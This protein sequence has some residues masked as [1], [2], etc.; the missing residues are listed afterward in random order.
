MS[1][2]ASRILRVPVNVVQEQTNPCLTIDDTTRCNQLAKM[3]QIMHTVY[4]TLL[5]ITKQ[6]AKAKFKELPPHWDIFQFWWTKLKNVHFCVCAFAVNKEEKVDE[7]R[8][9]K[10]VIGLYIALHRLF[11]SSMNSVL[12]MAKQDKLY[13]R[14]KWVCAVD[15]ACV[16]ARHCQTV[17]GPVVGNEKRCLQWNTIYFKNTKNTLIATKFWYLHRLANGQLVWMLTCFCLFYSGTKSLVRLNSQ[18][19]LL[20]ANKTHVWNSYPSHFLPKHT[21][22][23]L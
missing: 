4:H 14:L 6:N 18:T 8:K 22:F 17:S 11:H 9:R 5:I 10:K 19:V 7:P 1:V 23:F 16:C 13:H 20:T 15:G 3:K 12:F 2:V 21:L